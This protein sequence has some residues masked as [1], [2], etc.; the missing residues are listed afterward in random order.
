MAAGDL[1][2]ADW[3]AE[4]SGLLFDG[5]QGVTSPFRTSSIEGL[6]DLAGLNTS[7]R[8]R[9]RRH[10]IIPG[11]DFVAEREITWGLRI[12]SS[13]TESTLAA[14][15]LLR[16]ATAPGA[17]E[18]PL[19]FRIPG[20]GGGAKCQ[21]MARCRK[22]SIP[23]GMAYRVGIVEAA[24]AFIATDPRIYGPAQS[25]TTTLPSGGGGLDVPADVPFVIGTAVTGGSI[26]ATNSGTFDSP[27]TARIDGPCVNPRL[28]DLTH[29]RFIQ[30]NTSLDVGEWLDIN[31]DQRTVLFGGTASRYSTIGPGSAWF[32][33]PPGTSEI[34]FRAATNTAATMTLSWRSA[35][36]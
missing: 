26:M 17:P 1:V 30:F 23:T 8:P 2:T 18:S 28:I 16:A 6:A 11:D 36:V 33:L 29:D 21:V 19:V 25:Q 7:D 27:F 31:S 15:D 22:R 32:D 35:W 12:E 20:I 5:A 3:Q 9:L 13:T 10:G 24:L 14:C 34:T 4:W